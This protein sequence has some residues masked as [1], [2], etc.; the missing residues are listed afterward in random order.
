MFLLLLILVIL[1][2]FSIV[3]LLL[4]L[5]FYLC[6][7]NSVFRTH[8][9]VNRAGNNSACCHVALAI[10][11]GVSGSVRRRS[12]R[13]WRYLHALGCCHGNIFER[14]LWATSPQRRCIID[15]VR[16][17]CCLHENPSIGIHC[18]P[19]PNTQRKPYRVLWL[20]FSFQAMVD[21]HSCRQWAIT[22]RNF[23]ILEMS[24][25]SSII[26]ILNL[27]P[28]SFQ[29][30]SLLP[31]FTL[32]SGV[33]AVADGD[34]FS[35]GTN[36]ANNLFNTFLRTRVSLASAYVVSNSLQVS[37]DSLWIPASDSRWGRDTHTFFCINCWSIMIG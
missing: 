31:R 23:I 24:S 10:F 16:W 26:I 18:R 33:I 7:C 9:E 37:F 5:L 6:R 22:V 20:V 21:Y 1:I 11:G 3:L 29:R 36:V 8:S 35:D 2:M 12:L 27:F 14:E 15:R 30:Y 34:Q 17:D 28:S 4:L 19:F 13:E 32:G 25:S